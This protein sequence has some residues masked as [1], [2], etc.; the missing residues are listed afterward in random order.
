MIYPTSLRANFPVWHFGDRADRLNRRSSGQRASRPRFQTLYRGGASSVRRRSVIAYHPSLQHVALA[1]R[2]E[3]ARG[4]VTALATRLRDRCLERWC[5]AASNLPPRGFRSPER[6]CRSHRLRMLTVSAMNV[7]AA[8]FGIDAR[9]AEW[10]ET[11]PR[12]QHRR[13]RAPEASRSHSLANAARGAAQ[14][15]SL[16]RFGPFAP[17][18]RL[19]TVHFVPTLESTSPPLGAILGLV[20]VTRYQRCAV[21]PSLLG[22]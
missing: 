14:G 12:H 13:A 15:G 6:F 8:S 7:R 3:L 18:C 16:K 10:S 20:Q 21:L 11:G 1:A 5:S 17:A 4:T 9:A 19:H 22:V 2:P